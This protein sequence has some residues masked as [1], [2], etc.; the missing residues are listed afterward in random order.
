MKRDKLDAIFSKLVR[1]RDDWTCTCCGKRYER[2]SQGLHASHLVSRRYQSTRHHPL[3]AV[4]HCF[5]CHQRLGGNPLD[6]S[7]WINDYLG[8]EKV[9][10]LKTL[11]N[12]LCKRSKKDKEALYQHLKQQYREM[13]EMRDNGHEGRIEFAAFNEH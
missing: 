9:E 5:S 4:S 2:G 6:F 13:M 7:K 1:E 3:G 8:P 12:T 11:K 10:E